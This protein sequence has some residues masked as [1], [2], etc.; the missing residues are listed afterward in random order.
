MDSE[1]SDHT[2]DFILMDIESS[3]FNAILGGKEL[4]RRCS[5]FVVEF[6]PNHLERVSNRSINDLSQLLLEL[7]FDE[8]YFPT[9][10]LRGDPEQCLLAS[11]LSIADSKSFEDGI[12]FKRHT[13]TKPVVSV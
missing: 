10:Q 5:V 8:V 3:E 4:L 9:L 7:D 13:A 6:V 1:Y 11:L 12:I 2:F